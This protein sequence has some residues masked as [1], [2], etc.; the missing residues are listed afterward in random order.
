[1]SAPV[2]NLFK[3]PSK[4]AAKIR[5]PQPCRNEEECGY[6]ELQVTTHFSF[7]RGA[8]SPNQIFYA[9]DKLGLKTIA[10]TDRN[11]LAGMVRALAA[12]REVENTHLVVGCRLDLRCGSSLL[13]YPTDK[14]AYSRLCRLLSRG[15]AR[16]GK[17]ACD[18]GWDDVGEWCEGLIGILLLDSVEDPASRERMA[19]FA[20]LFADR[21][22]LAL[23]IHRRPNDGPRLLALSNLAAAF[24]IPTVATGDVLYHSNEQRPLQDVVTC[25]REKCTIDELG[26][27][28]ERNADRDLKSEAEMRRLFRFYLKDDLP[29]SRTAEI[30][31]RCT[32]RMEDLEYEY[33]EEA[34]IPG[35]TPQQALERL[36][37]EAAAERYPGDIPQKVRDQLDYELDLIGQM[38]YAP[39]FLT[40]NRIVAWARSQG[41]LCQGRGSAANSTVCYV[42]GI[43]ALDPTIYSL[44]FDRFVSTHRR[45]PPDI[46]VDFDHE[47]REE[48]IQWIFETYG[49]DRAAMCAT[50]AKFRSRG[51]I[52]E[53][54]KA[55]GLT[56]DMT[57]ALSAQVSGWSVEGVTDAH[58]AELGFDAASSERLRLAAQLSRQ[59]IGTPRHLSQHPG[60]FVLTRQ[61]LDQLAVIEPAAMKDRQVV[62][63]DKDDID[64]L[65]MMKVDILGLGMLGCM[66]G[67]F[68]LLN[69]YKRIE[70]E[71]NVPIELHE[72]PKEDV[73]TYEM[74]QKAD[75][76]GVFQIESRAQMSM[77]PRLRPK[78][79]Y[80]LVVQIAIVRPGPIQGD[81][82]HPY[83]RRREG[84]EKPEYPKPELE[85]LLKHTYGVPLFQE[86]AMNIA[87]KC[88]GFTPAEADQLRRSM[89][90]FKATGGV[91][92]F[93]DKLVEGMIEKGYTREFAE[94]IFH[95]IEGFGSYGFPESHA[96]SFA[97]LAYASSWVKCHHP[98]VFCCALLNAQP[99][100]FYAPAQIVRDAR[101]H[102]V[103]IRAPDINLS[104]W[105]S[106]LEPC[107]TSS[108]GFAVRLGLRVAKSFREPLGRQVELAR[109]G[110]S[111]TS[112]D[113]LVWR[114]GLDVPGLVALARADAFGSLGLNRRQALWATRGLRDRPLSLFEAADGRRAS[115]L[116]E[117]VEAPVPLVR[118]TRGAEVVEDYHSRE[119]S[120]RDHP[121]AF[122]RGDLSAL[123]A[124]TCA[125]VDEGRDGRAAMV[126][127][128]VLVRQR[129]GSAKGVMFIT[130]ED[131]TGIANLVVW[132][133]RFDRFRKTI[134]TGGLLGAKGR[135][136]RSREWDRERQ[137][138]IP[139]QVVHLVVEDL[140]DLSHLLRRVG[141][142]ET[143]QAFKRTGRGDS[144][145]KSSTPDRE[146]RVRAP[147]KIQTRDFR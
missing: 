85:E 45:E 74:I 80:D 97:I 88:G 67:A 51:A 129:P 108:G 13:V 50:V 48:V 114:A 53:V 90:T 100:G 133:D 142:R 54:G 22:Y 111:Y 40:V 77:L 37:W 55:L 16:A 47:R 145:W 112:L 147:I 136:Q 30:P 94:R 39:Y 25:I 31:A 125:S 116:P 134:L 105:D 123:G 121:L 3:T 135:I 143:G 11:S 72:V 60:G 20:T 10:I 62:E 1:M 93:R 115:L 91:S 58:I 6:A 132:P 41:I 73:A 106:T 104:N 14:A 68:D 38:D 146:D 86:Q 15:K 96:A 110:S 9:A 128:L 66:R 138:D 109:M 139:G 76:L 63:W 124:S 49:R 99:M 95:Q 118:M 69:K 29:V 78:E 141:Q 127:G 33:P 26:L 56:E 52:R 4:R 131:E 44:L 117:A 21:A 84:R 17:G 119:L 36:S 130:L 65:K 24:G 144:Y 81:M 83:L 61:P 7:L 120:L 92:G 70:G 12:S 2:Q 18:I 5:E 46:D 8:S 89:A 107:T 32:F 87:I 27:R 102:G 75:T 35:L 98:D 19:T 113:D 79:F 23:S 140:I 64:I 122:L 126:A 103:E 71:E 42:L 101:D 43:T 34:H 59:L 137:T 82:V 28:R 57:A